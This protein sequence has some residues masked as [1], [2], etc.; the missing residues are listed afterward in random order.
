MITFQQTIDNLAA[1]IGRRKQLEGKPSGWFATFSILFKCGV[2][3]VILYR[4]SHYLVHTRFGFLHKLLAI[5][6]Q[7][8]SKNEISA[9]ATAG[10]GLVLGDGGG[11]GLT[12]VAI[13]GKNCTFL[14]CNS[15]TLGAME[16]FDVNLHHI[17]IGDH[18]VI[19]ASVRIMRPV[20]IAAG[21]QIKNNAVVMF[22]ADK[23]GSVLSGIPAKRRSVETYE[24]VIAWNPLKGGYL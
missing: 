5:I 18:C 13:V 14:G 19:G 2:V 7:V 6:D 12:Q 17:V 16:D 4:F 3:S 21:T 11:I 24:N 15:I 9:H 23:V 1:D 20:E 10:P 22:S 8:Y